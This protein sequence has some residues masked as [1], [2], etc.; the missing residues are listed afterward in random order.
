MRSKA[1][2]DA[3][4]MSHVSCAILLLPSVTMRARMTPTT[5][6]FHTMLQ[7]LALTQGSRSIGSDRLSVITMEAN[8]VAS[9]QPPS[10]PY[11]TSPV[12]STMNIT[13]RKNSDACSPVPSH[14]QQ[15]QG[16]GDILH[17]YSTG[18]RNHRRSDWD[19]SIPARRKQVK[20]RR[21]DRA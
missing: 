4:N 16:P 2:R 3:T 20:G 1:G 7:S 9:S 5:C 19:R 17:G 10:L 18:E 12:R 11:H 14:R 8:A 6:I 15:R 13:R 21:E